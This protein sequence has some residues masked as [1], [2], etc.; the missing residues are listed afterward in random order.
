MNEKIPFNRPVITGREIG[1][2]EEVL[3]NLRFSGDGPMSERCNAWLKEHLGAHAALVTTSCT[4]ALEMA[5]MLCDLKPGDEVILPSYGFSSTATAFARA[6]ANLVF[7]DIEPSTMNLSVSAAE[8]AVSAKTRAIIALH[9]AGVGCSMDAI[10][11]LALKYNLH[12]I[13]DAAQGIF[14]SYGTRPLGT[15][16]TFGCISFHESKNIHCGEGGAL[17]INDPAFIER[18]EIILEKGTNRIKFRRGGESKYTWCDLGSSYVLSDLNCGFLLAQLEAGREITEDRLNTWEQY[19]GYLQD[20]ADREV[21][22]IPRAYEPDQHNGHIFWVKLKDADARNHLMTFL[23]D[24]NIMATFHYI[25]LH[26]AP[27][28]PRYGRFSGQDRYTTIESQRLLR[29]PMYH[30]FRDVD[31][32]VGAIYDYFS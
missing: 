30:G 18:A 23:H 28:G 2:I 15:I 20:L 22:E 17:V 25:P 32:V 7:V 19:R 9:Y 16:G 24:L 13:E 6:G 21:L 10:C 27:A 31:R 5:A 29:L 1:Y 26:S 14:S 12:V 4:D 3:G 8:E 11:Q